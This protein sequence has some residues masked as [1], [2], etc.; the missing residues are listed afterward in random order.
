MSSN[1]CH[2]CGRELSSRGA[3]TK[4][5]DRKTPCDK[6]LQCPLCDKEF[7]NYGNFKKH[8]NQKIPCNQVGK[9]CPYC[10]SMPTT[11]FNYNRHVIKCRE[12]HKLVV[13]GPEDKIISVDKDK[14][15]VT[16]DAGYLKELQK[17][18]A[19][20]NAGDVHNHITINNVQQNIIININNYGDELDAMQIEP[21]AFL[22]LLKA[23]GSLMVSQMARLLHNNPDFEQNRNVVIDVDTGDPL[24][25]KEGKWLG[26]PMPELVMDVKSKMRSVARNGGSELHGEVFNS[27]DTT[28][29]TNW[30][31]INAMPKDF[32]IVQPEEI[33]GTRDVLPKKKKDELQVK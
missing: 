15:T 27:N 30:Y 26:K 8:I 6:K 18:A 14:H 31:K 5:L 25:Y 2:K 22:E 16:V 13:T 17:A 9:P 4:H 10:D 20:S 29:Q 28:V 12:K 19:N 33:E 23:D 24:V 32:Q 7:D 21:S 1:V 11:A 3:L